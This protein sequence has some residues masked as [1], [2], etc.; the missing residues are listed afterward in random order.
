ME[1]LKNFQIMKTKM[2][3]RLKMNWWYHAYISN[4]ACLAMNY[5]SCT[6]IN[7]HTCP[8]KLLIV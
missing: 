5:N 1:I 4:I 3:N 2:F 6:G 7:I 8:A